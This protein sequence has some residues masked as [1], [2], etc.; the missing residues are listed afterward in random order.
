MRRLWPVIGDRIW[1]MTMRRPPTREEERALLERAAAGDVAARN[2]LVVRHR[3]FALRLAHGVALRAP[4]LAEDLAQEAVIGL[5]DA[6]LRFDP[7]RETRFLTFA[8]WHVRNRVGRY[9]DRNRNAVRPHMGNRA[10]TARRTFGRVWQQVAQEVGGEPT[11][12]QLAERVGVAPGIAAVI[13]RESD[14]EAHL[15][16][17]AA[18]GQSPEDFVAR[19]E[20]LRDVMAAVDGLGER[21]RA[22]V[23]AYAG[24]QTMRAIGEE[25]GITTQRVQQLHA[26]ALRRLREALTAR[27]EVAA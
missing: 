10:R 5:M 1:T 15:R 25:L 8:H 26:R 2:E 24:G 3:P 22:I 20:E 21:D 27:W 12:E 9:L 7:E 14:G 11:R 23:R 6:V 17:I 4:H 13:E 19:D 18:E 16:R